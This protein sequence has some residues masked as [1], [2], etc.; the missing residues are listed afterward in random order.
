MDH[1][2][3]K[4]RTNNNQHDSKDLSNMDRD[5][6]KK[7]AHTN[8][9]DSKDLPHMNREDIKHS[10]HMNNQDSRDSSNAN[11]Q[12]SKDSSSANRHDAK[13]APDIDRSAS[14]N[15]T[16]PQLKQRFTSVTDSITS[17]N[18]EYKH[19]DSIQSKPG[20]V[21]NRKKVADSDDDVDYRYDKPKIVS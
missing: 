9:Q 18:D 19:Q 3:P 16:E 1:D 6:A 8:R 4:H 17:A 11:R 12:D 15:R 2:D 5:D 20:S 13:R 21:S 14:P 10:T 7:A